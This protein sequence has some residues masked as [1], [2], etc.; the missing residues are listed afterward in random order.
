MY[1]S[2][3]NSKDKIVVKADP[4]GAFNAENVE[5]LASKMTELGRSMKADVSLS[6][7]KL[8][9]TSLSRLSC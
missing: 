3:K 9:Q 1:L 8:T 4:N 7:E 6:F 2:F 5:A